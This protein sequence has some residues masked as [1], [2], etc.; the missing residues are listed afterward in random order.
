[1]GEDVGVLEG[2]KVKVGV[3]VGVKVGVVEAV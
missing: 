3:T 1:M 2:A